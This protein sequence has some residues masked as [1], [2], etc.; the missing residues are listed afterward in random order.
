MLY[1]SMNISLTDIQISELSL[2]V[3]ELL[4]H[5]LRITTPLDYYPVL[6][7]SWP[8]FKKLKMGLD[9]MIQFSMTLKESAEYSAEELLYGAAMAVVEYKKVRVSSGQV[10]LLKSIIINWS[11]VETLAKIILREFHKEEE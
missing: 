10:D 2:N 4:G 7:E 1:E 6:F 5:Q 9:F 8:E 11:R 3:F